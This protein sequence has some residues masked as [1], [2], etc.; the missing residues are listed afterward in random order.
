[1]ELADTDDP[2]PTQRCI[3]TWGF[4][5]H[6][7]LGYTCAASDRSQS[8]PRQAPDAQA[9][10]PINEQT[11]TN[12][13]CGSYVSAALTS[14]QNVFVWGRGM[15]SSVSGMIRFIINIGKKC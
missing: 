8:T 13:T 3:L 11:V 6:G 10:T 12:V 1:M 9:F 14:D 15:I 5:G 2:T 4:A 7:I